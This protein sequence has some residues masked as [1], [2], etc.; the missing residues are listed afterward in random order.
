MQT[1]FIR[2]VAMLLLLMLAACASAP[3]PRLPAVKEHVVLSDKQARR[4]LRNGNLPLARA[5]YQQSLRLSQ[6]LDDLPGV[7]TA[8]INLASV[9]HGLKKDEEALRLLDGLLGEKQVP[10]PEDLRTMAAF[11]KAVILVG[12]NSEAAPAAVAVAEQMCA[13][14]CDLAAGLLNLEARMALNKKDYAAAVTLASD[15]AGRAGDSRQELANARR[16]MATAELA[17]GR[18]G[19]ALSHFQQALELDKGLGLAKRIAVD[20]DGISTVLG[21]LGRKEEAA[22]Y[23]RRA[24]AAHEANRAMVGMATEQ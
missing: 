18:N 14:S 24:A 17:L 23:A 19:Q 6:A 5:L 22:A 20:L 16:H 3:P 12:N 1:A 2:I 15:A 4:A 10:Y 8:T 9:Y 13:R 21:K 11:R 7:A